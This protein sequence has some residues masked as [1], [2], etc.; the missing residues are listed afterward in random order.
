MT[1]EELEIDL[2]HVNKLKRSNFS[3]EQIVNVVENHLSGLVL[4]PLGRKV[5][6]SI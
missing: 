4:R 1:Y 5:Y 6:E 3:S 2:E